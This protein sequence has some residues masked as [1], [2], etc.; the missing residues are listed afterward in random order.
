MDTLTP[1]TR[2]MVLGTHPGRNQPSM[3]IFADWIVTALR[4]RADVSLRRPP[5]LFLN[6]VVRRWRIAK[7]LFYVDQFVILPVF[8]MF[9]VRR[10]DMLIVAD[11]SNAPATMLVPR[12]KLVA[13][14]HDMVGVRLALEGIADAPPAGRGGRLMQ[15]MVL[16]SLRRMQRLAVSAN[17]VTR[18]LAA[19]DVV[20]P[21]TA[22]GC[23]LDMARLGQSRRPD[24][25]ASRL[26]GRQFVLNVATDDWRK[27]KPFLVQSWSSLVAEHPDAPVLVL[28]GYT[29]PDTAAAAARTSDA[30]IVAAE[31]S[32]AELVWL[33]EHCVATIVASTEEG[34]CIPILES[35]Y[36]SKPVLGVRGAAY[37]EIF[38]DAILPFDVADP[39][40]AAAEFYAMLSDEDAIARGLARRDEIVRHYSFAQF[41]E[42]LVDAFD[43]RPSEVPALEKASPPPP[44]IESRMA[45]QTVCVIS[46]YTPLSHGFGGIARATGDY[47][48]ALTRAGLPC[49]LIASSA[50]LHGKVDAASIAAALPGVTALLFDA[51][52]S[53]RWG[54]G[55]GFLR[56]LPV[57][58]RSD[59]VILQ[60]IRSFPTMVA[61]VACRLLRRPY[62]IVA[63][64]TLDRSRVAQ[65]RAKRPWL[66]ALT[67]AFVS[68]A[69]RG[70]RAIIVTGA[71]EQRTLLED[72]ASLPT[73]WIENFFDFTAADV[74]PKI[75]TLP[76]IYLFVGR[77]EP[78]K[79]IL[80]F[81]RVWR[82][83]ARADSRLVLVGSGTGAYCD[84]V[85]GEAADDRRISYL[86]EVSKE[87][88]A[89]LMMEC[90]ISVLPT[91]M[92]APVTENFGNVIVEAFIA[93]RPAMVAE[94]L[95]WDEYRSHPAVLSF[96]PT[97]A[98]AADAIRRFD[99]IDAATYA[100]MS[101]SAVALAM[102]FHVE[103]AVPQV[104]ELVAEAIAR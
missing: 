42:R 65:T 52:V 49:T 72:A 32:D 19:F 39:A 95:H 6:R 29:R 94:G 10:Y 5:A 60:G 83:V 73:R 12:R 76:R 17:K 57:A 31:M 35:L 90:A 70:A 91:G 74:R 75:L 38:G 20:R 33:Y 51:R 50:S 37:V 15:R 9:A 104:K 43:L 44:P 48:A 98:G 99:A 41:S 78:D 66:F 89:E 101:A 88:V 40:R 55:L 64:A 18:E 28:A 59:L 87:R 77:L 103:R 3:A 13:M 92:D 21:T 58:L 24:A 4:S 47:L 97:P 80:G 96:A 36:F 82:S 67:Q 27:R 1:S 23:T 102:G 71:L 100:A 30:V 46:P 79:G 61:G 84:T 68:F 7:W 2:I 69:A 22:I 56:R 85:L 93:G 11:H 8:L 14:V 16:A 62:Y 26:A 54:L 81:L 53:P 63:H 25:V 45:R 34:F 86:G